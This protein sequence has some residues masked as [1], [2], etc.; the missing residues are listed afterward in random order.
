MSQNP[1][2]TTNPNLSS[3]LDCG[4]LCSLSATSC[5]KC[6]R[7]FKTGETQTQPKDSRVSCAAC[8]FLIPKM[9]SVCVRCGQRRVGD[10]IQELPPLTVKGTTRIN[11]SKRATI[12]GVGILFLAASNGVLW[13]SGSFDKRQDSE[14]VNSEP[15]QANTTTAQ[16]K[17]AAPSSP[18]PTPIPKPAII[19]WTY[20][21]HTRPQ[22]RDGKPYYFLADG[23]LADEPYYGNR[24]STIHVY[25]PEEYRKG[26]EYAAKSAAAMVSDVESYIGSK[27]C[28]LVEGKVIGYQ[29]KLRSGT[30]L[31]VVPQDR[32]LKSVIM[33]QTLPG[34]EPIIEIGE[35]SP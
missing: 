21:S 4:N 33:V 20:L 30:N 9:A 31:L 11:N 16:P 3:C 27:V 22:I 28:D 13:W 29:F 32:L 34:R 7:P 35:V 15:V 17:P 1:Q 10:T 26:G 12:I 19:E 24:D 5:P 14:Q 6:G 18:N 25:I 8:G 23:F 2:S